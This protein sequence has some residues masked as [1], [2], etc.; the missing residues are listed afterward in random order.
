[1]DPLP[2]TPRPQSLMDYLGRDKAL[3]AAQLEL[4][5]SERNKLREVRRG[6]WGRMGADSCAWGGGGEARWLREGSA[7]EGEGP[8]DQTQATIS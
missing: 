6:R 7:G 4:L 8:H 2:F 5:S 3:A 1:M